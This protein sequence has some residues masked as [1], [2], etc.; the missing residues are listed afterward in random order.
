M[1][2]SF[3]DAI[4]A[5][6]ASP[7][8]IVE[9]LQLVSAGCAISPL[10]N[11]G[12]GSSVD[13]ACVQRGF[14]FDVPSTGRQDVVIQSSNALVRLRS[15]DHGDL[16]PGPGL[17]FAPARG[18]VRVAIDGPP[19]RYEGIVSEGIAEVAIPATTVTVDLDG[20]CSAQRIPAEI[21]GPTGAA[22]ALVRRWGSA[23]QSVAFDVV[24][25]TSG[26]LEID[27]ASGS[28]VISG[29]SAPRVFF[30]CGQ[31]CPSNPAADCARDDIFEIT[32]GI[33]PLRD[34]FGA[35]VVPDQTL[36]FQTGP[37]SA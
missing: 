34:V 28:G 31:A 26:L 4:A 3:D 12:Q 9:D 36:H 18:D 19:G 11:V 10:L 22:F 35:P 7:Q 15:C 24:G 27:S 23:E 16:I 20:A 17:L 8:P 2:G 6:R 30:L 25:R 33:D 32:G 37:R 1:G 13:P 14:T 21:G 5:W 29:D